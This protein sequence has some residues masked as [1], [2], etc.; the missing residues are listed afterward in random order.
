MTA[1]DINCDRG[2]HDPVA[3]SANGSFST[4]IDLATR[5]ATGG[6][7][8]VGG[9]LFAKI[10]RFLTQILL[11]RVLGVS[12]YG[13]YSLAESIAL[14]GQKFSLLGL[15]EG[16]VRFGSIYKQD[17]N[18]G[19]LKSL[20]G[21]ALAVGGISGLLVSLGLF[22]AAE[23]I[24]VHVFGEPELSQT[25]RLLV[26][27]LPFFGVM[28][29]VASLARAKQRMRYYTGLIDVLNPLLV[30]SAI[31]IAFLLG[32]HLVG[33]VAA[34]TIATI[35]SAIGALFMLHRIAP[36]F[37]SSSRTRVKFGVIMKYSLVISLRSSALLLLNRTDRVMLGLLADTSDVGIY[38]AAATLATQTMIAGYAF[39]SILAPIIANL[40]SMNRSDEIRHVLQT[41]MRWVFTI[42][43]PV[44]L[45][46]VLFPKQLLGL[47]GSGFAVGS[48]VLIVL[49]LA[50]LGH[51]G[52]SAL[53]QMLNMTGHQNLE[54][55]NSVGL[56]VLNIGL[57]VVLIPM[58]GP[59]GAAISTGSSILLV[60]LVRL[61]QVRKLFGFHPFT[62]KYMKPILAAGAAAVLWLL[63]RGWIFGSSLGWI[64][65][66]VGILLI[67][68]AALTALRIEALDWMV[69]K[70]LKQRI[71]RRER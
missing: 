33:A 38:S 62:R 61:V 27:S 58:Y 12:A 7:V 65:G 71:F 41:T 32:F 50:Q 56:L 51:A 53:A 28:S 68:V 2:V 63:L 4:E 55:F 13:V 70:A 57:N 3:S 18:C 39:N 37:R 14:I 11:A 20:F 66:I 49:A 9:R 25:L 1:K 48:G 6:G 22:L 67:Y 34:F 42:S 31:A 17:E 60:A 10:L 8:V 19:R 69:L 35:G 59:L 40:H 54:L 30:L 43:V 24:A 45:V 64:G 46:L 44:C 36:C 23:P 21:S 52:V 47:Y 29:L 15:S 16:I 5:V 26:W